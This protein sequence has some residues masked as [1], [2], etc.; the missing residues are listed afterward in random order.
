MLQIFASII[1]YRTYKSVKGYGGGI[2]QNL[3]IYIRT[4]MIDTYIMI[5]M[6]KR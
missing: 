6:M 3:Y 5:T 1:I 2:Y 4:Y